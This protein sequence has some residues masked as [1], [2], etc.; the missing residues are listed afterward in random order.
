MPTSVSQ[1]IQDMAA[2][3]EVVIVTETGRGGACHHTICLV[4]LHLREI[5]T[6]S[7]SLRQVLC[8]LQDIIADA[9]RA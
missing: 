2:G 5:P 4:I 1:S 9:A 8:N 7:S 6:M 3:R